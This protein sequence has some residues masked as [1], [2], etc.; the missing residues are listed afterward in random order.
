MRRV[1]QG[2]K[3]K[4]SSREEQGEIRKPFKMKSAK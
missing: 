2:R 1:R 3:G 4:Q